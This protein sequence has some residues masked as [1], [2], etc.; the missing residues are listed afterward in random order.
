MR[1]MWITALM[2]IASVG[3]FAQSGKRLAVVNGEVITDEQVRSA[4]SDE[5]QALET[6]RLQFDLDM[7]RNAS[8]AMENALENILADR[9]LSAEAKKT[10]VTRDQLIAA[11][12]DSKIPVPSDDAVEKF[13]NE[14]QGRINM[15]REQ[16]LPQIRQYLRGQQ[17][18]RSLYEY[19]QKLKQDYAVESYFEPERSVVAIDGHPVQGSSQ[20]AVTIVEFSDFE[21]PYCSALYPTLKEIEKNYADKVR[22]VYRQFPLTN[23]HPHAM[24]AAEASLCA[25]EQQKF[26]ELHD[27]M[28]TDQENL[29]I[30]ALKQ[31][32]G[33][34]NLN[35]DQFGQ[36]LD[37]S[38]YAAAVR[39]DLADGT[40]L[41][42]TGTPA[43][44]VN[45]RFL[46][47]AVPY[48]EVSRIIDDELRRAAAKK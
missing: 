30:E 12:V 3:G 5:I 26:W 2:M 35:A 14:N 8:N 6:K 38:K 19:I 13:W 42:V 20:A 21:C 24:K 17:R 48:P 7:A 40:K 44:F 31:K 41:G 23:L 33:R 22:I 37:S 43:M 10:A 34:L 15:T 27:A 47:G 28:F 9:L 11:E 36:C 45:G 29:T 25:N 32:A 16:A 1:G 18:D 46:G 39:S 4:A